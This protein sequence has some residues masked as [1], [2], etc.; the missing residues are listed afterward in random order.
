MLLVDD[1]AN[2]REVIS[3]LLR[4]ARFCVIEA[5]SGEGAVEILSR[6]P[7]DIILTD[8]HMPDGDGIF[9]RDRVNALFPGTP[10]L[11][12]TGDVRLSRAA[13]FSGFSGIIEKP[14]DAWSLPHDLRGLLSR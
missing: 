11:L 8:V 12:M 7:V 14:I 3:R 4:R 6:L 13:N 10:V 5:A 2:V 1:C 9:L